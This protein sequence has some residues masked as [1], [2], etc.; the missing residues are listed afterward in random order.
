MVDAPP[1]IPRVFKTAWFVKEARKA[2]I[3]DTELC[4]TFAEIR[5]GQCDDLGGGVYKKRLNKNRHRSIVLAKGG[6][7]WIYQYLFAK[8]D[9]DN[10]DEKE[11][12]AF[13]KLAK[14]YET[15]TPEQLSKLLEA[16]D[17]TEI[18]HVDQ[19]KIQK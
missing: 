16:K 18:C 13:R 6:L 10:I 17:L 8:K 14:Y 2:L 12:E 5:K 3:R 15:L 11:L 9:R 4:E 19:A 1:Q 7:H